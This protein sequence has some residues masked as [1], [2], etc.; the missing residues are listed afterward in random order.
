MLYPHGAPGRNRTCMSGLGDQ[1]LSFSEGL[2]H[3]PGI[4]P[5]PLLRVMETLSHL[6]QR[7]CL[8]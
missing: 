6:A 5:G 4:E 2:V 3:A 7:A 8:T 1:S